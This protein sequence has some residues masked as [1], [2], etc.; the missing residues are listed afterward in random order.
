VI[1]M[2]DSD[3]TWGEFCRAIERPG[4][5]DDHRFSHSSLRGANSQALMAELDAAFGTR[6]LQTWRERL[7]ATPIAWAPVQSPSDV[8]RDQQVVANRYIAQVK[9]GDG[10]T[11]AVPTNPARFDEQPITPGRSPEHGEHT[12]QI[13]IEAGYD[14]DAITELKATKAVM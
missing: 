1:N 12:E 2:L 9:A 8:H 7:S 5:F 6:P 4:L 11:I 3:R 13:L 10:Q 14:W